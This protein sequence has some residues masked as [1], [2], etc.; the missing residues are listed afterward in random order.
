M[1]PDGI[2]VSTF[3]DMNLIKEIYYQMVNDSFITKYVNLPE[4]INDKSIEVTEYDKQCNR[5]LNKLIN[6][7]KKYF[8]NYSKNKATIST[9]KYITSCSSKIKKNYFNSITLIVIEGNG[10]LLLKK[11]HLN[12]I[13]NLN[14]LTIVT[15]ECDKLVN[16][17]YELICDPFLVMVE[18]KEYSDELYSMKDIP[19]V[20]NKVA[21]TIINNSKLS[22]KKTVIV[23]EIFNFNELYN[24]SKNKLQITPNKFYVQPGSELNNGD[25]LVTEMH[26]F[27]SEGECYNGPTKKIVPKKEINYEGVPL[28]KYKPISDWVENWNMFEYPKLKFKTIIGINGIAFD[29]E[30]IFDLDTLNNLYLQSSVIAPEFQELVNGIK[31]TVEENNIIWGI[32][33]D[34]VPNRHTTIFI[35]DTDG[36]FIGFRGDGEKTCK[37]KK[38]EIM[39]C[40]R[41]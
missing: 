25:V 29:Q 21:I 23:S 9:K 18:C 11:G 2:N 39:N 13:I 4:P 20:Q 19:I 5:C 15:F 3:F 35:V 36:N 41:L 27:I 8:L 30:E 22:E 12:H 31:D 32:D 34:D 14:A 17:T 28:L 33:T 38:N 10:K 40:I 37:G 1:L 6:R 7:C 16:W 26:I 24:I